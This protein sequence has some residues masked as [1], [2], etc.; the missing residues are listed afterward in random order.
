MRKR[1]PVPP[2]RHLRSA[3]RTIEEVVFKLYDEQLAAY[4]A[5]VLAVSRGDKREIRKLFRAKLTAFGDR[6]AL[7]ER[8]LTSKERRHAIRLTA[9]EA[10]IESLH[11]AVKRLRS[12]M[13]A[14]YMQQKR[15]K[16]GVLAES[17]GKHPRLASTP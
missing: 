2:T 8:K 15:F 4:I 3:I 6:S 7:L 5:Y 16:H 10:E 14:A 13:E 17:E 11:D 9:Y 12:R 1:R